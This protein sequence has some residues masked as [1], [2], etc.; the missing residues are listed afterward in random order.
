MRGGDEGWGCGKGMRG[1]DEDEGMRGGDEGWGS[2]A[3]INV[4][5]IIEELQFIGREQ[6][7]IVKI[8]VQCGIHHRLKVC[9]VVWFRKVVDTL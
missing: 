3:T 6:V 4:L 5:E 7:E 1:G 8:W 2:V 9:Q